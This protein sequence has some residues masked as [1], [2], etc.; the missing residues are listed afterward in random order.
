MICERVGASLLSNVPKVNCHPSHLKFDPK[1]HVQQ[2]WPCAFPK[3][4]T[5]NKPYFSL[6]MGRLA[7]LLAISCILTDAPL[8]TYTPPQVS[9][10]LEET[11]SPQSQRHFLGLR[12]AQRPQPAA[13]QAKF[14]ACSTSPQTEFPDHGLP[15]L[16]QGIPASIS[17]APTLRPQ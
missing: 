14:G 15:E 13:G 17:P 8:H 4:H 10:P 5:P 1:K 16:R 9:P 12:R 6:R 11:L 2:G 7:R 3:R